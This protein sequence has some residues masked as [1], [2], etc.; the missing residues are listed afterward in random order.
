M[1]VI[2]FSKYAFLITVPDNE[3]AVEIT[4][5]QYDG[6]KNGTMQFNDSLA[7]VENTPA[8]V[9]EERKMENLRARRKAECFSIIN[10]G[11]LWY[12]R[13][14]QEQ[15]VQLNKWYQDWLDVT[16]T[17]MIPTKPMWIK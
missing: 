11:Q 10:R 14:S 5:E 7:A 13:L 6:L 15:L 12:S 8:E 3:S 1:R 2:P 16:E 4:T 17:G 9:I